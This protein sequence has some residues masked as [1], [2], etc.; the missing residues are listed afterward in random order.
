MTTFITWLK[1]EIDIRG[2]SQAELARRSSL[3]TGAISH[4]FSGSRRPG[5]D[6]CTAIANALNYPP[7]LVFRKAGLL[8]ELDHTDPP[9]TDE[10]THRFKNADGATQ[11][12]ILD[13]V[14]F[15]TSR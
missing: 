11:R 13:F 5:P 2:I 6:L 8:P 12:E 1:N 15:K 14:R 10:L 4:I 3:T 7:D 9:G